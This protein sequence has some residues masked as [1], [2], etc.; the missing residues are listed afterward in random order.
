MSRS[1]NPADLARRI[2]ATFNTNPSEPARTPPIYKP[3]HHP[4]KAKFDAELMVYCAVL[5]MQSIDRLTEAVRELSYITNSV[6]C[7]SGL[8][9]EDLPYALREWIKNKCPP[10]P[11]AIGN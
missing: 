11:N 6:A 7:G 8:L 1:D 4:H 2:V 5:Q 10:D 3:P 9:D